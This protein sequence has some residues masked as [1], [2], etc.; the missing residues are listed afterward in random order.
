[1]SGAA[2]ENDIRAHLASDDSHH[3]ERQLF[4][5]Q[6]GPL[7]N[8]YFHKSQQPIGIKARSGQLPG[9]PAEIP[10]RRF[11]CHAVGVG[12]FQIA[13]V[14]GSRQS[15]AA[16]VSLMKAHA[17][18]ICKCNDLDSERKANLVFVQALNTGNGCEHTE[19]A[20]EFSRVANCI[21]MRAEQQLLVVL[22]T[23]PFSII[24]ANQIANRVLASG[25]AGLRSEEHTSELQSLAYLVCRL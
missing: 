22:L 19:R 1:M 6:H 13:R 25:H 16:Q 24:M 10:D 5:F 9:V 20:I 21:Q 14:E 15:G 12:A 23:S 8:M 18:F 7:F 4:P 17:F 11:H 3:P 2:L